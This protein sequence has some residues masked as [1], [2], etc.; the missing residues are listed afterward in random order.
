[1]RFACFLLLVG[2]VRVL[3]LD[4]GAEPREATC[5]AG[6]A[7]GYR[8]PSTRWGLASLY[9]SRRLADRGESA[10]QLPPE[11]FLASA[12]QATGF[13][14]AAYG[15]PFTSDASA[16]SD[17][18]CLAIR[19]ETVWNEVCR[20]YPGVFDCGGYVGTLT[21][22]A[23]EAS[24]LTLAW[25]SVASN[26]LLGRLDVDPNAFYADATDPWAE[27]RLSA[28]LHVGGPF[29]DDARQV[30]EECGDDVV[31]C[32]DGD[33]AAHVEGLTDKIARLEEASCA[34]VEVTETD[35]VG[36]VDALAGFF[37][38]FDREAALDAVRAAE[39]TLAATVAAVEEAAPVMLTCPET[40]LWQWYRL[41]CP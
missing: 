7:T 18:G 28:A 5:V 15:D 10:P 35:R 23:P 36:F 1:M 32:L 30:V 22:D 41:P 8:L 40:E 2:C 26:A 3:D 25:F 24:V 34:E 33:V 31:A 11:W 38:A 12:W 21:G 29:L 37:P 17:A 4:E 39:P 9:A 19:S 14:C 27:E 16:E 20:L 13:G 6:A